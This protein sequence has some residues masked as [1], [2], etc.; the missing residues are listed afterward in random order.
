M[1]S[2]PYTF[3]YEFSNSFFIFLQDLLKI[4]SASKQKHFR[5]LYN[6]CILDI[7]AQYVNNAV[8]KASQCTNSL[9]D[10]CLAIDPRVIL[11]T[12]RVPYSFSL[13]NKYF[14]SNIVDE[15]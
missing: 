1:K 4:C 13:S 9:S 12:R 14:E 10:S 8:W 7:N 2:H 6:S 11:T 3:T 15:S 5:Q